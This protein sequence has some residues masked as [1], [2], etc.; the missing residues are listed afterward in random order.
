LQGISSRD[1]DILDLLRNTLTDW[2]IIIAGM[3][4]LVGILNLVSVQM[5]K[6]RTRQKGGMYGAL[7]VFSLVI[8]FGLGLVFGP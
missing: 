8:T 5:E 7:L 3:A 6:V 1:V 4:V 2:A